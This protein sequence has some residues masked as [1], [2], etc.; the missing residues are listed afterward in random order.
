MPSGLGLLKWEFR[1][2]GVPNNLFSITFVVWRRVDET[3]KC[4]ATGTQSSVWWRQLGDVI[5]TQHEP[6]TELESGAVAKQMNS[7]CPLELE[8]GKELGRGEKSCRSSLSSQ[9]LLKLLPHSRSSWQRAM[10]YSMR[11]GMFRELQIEEKRV[12]HHIVQEWGKEDMWK[13]SRRERC[14]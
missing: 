6:K 2:I 13:K 10:E 5:A 3:V 1:I 12:E 4:Q 9:V 8:V 11:L 7:A 14:A